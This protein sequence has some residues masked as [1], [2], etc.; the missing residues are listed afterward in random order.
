[1]DLSDLSQNY[2]FVIILSKML[3]HKKPRKIGVLESGVEDRSKQFT[4]K[5]VEADG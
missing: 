5:R 2:N 1:M 3:T 4:W